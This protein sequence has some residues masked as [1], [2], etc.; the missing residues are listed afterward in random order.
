MQIIENKYSAVSAR[1]KLYIDIYLH[2]AL[3]IL[4]IF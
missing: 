3:K 2:L 1:C 4:K